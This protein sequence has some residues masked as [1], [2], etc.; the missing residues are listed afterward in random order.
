MK[1]M[2]KTGDSSDALLWN[3]LQQESQAAVPHV[4]QLK[5]STEEA[6]REAKMLREENEHAMSVLGPR[7]SH[8]LSDTASQMITPLNVGGIISGVESCGVGLKTSDSSPFCVTAVKHVLDIM[9]T[10]QVP[11]HTLKRAASKMLH[12]VVCCV[13]SVAHAE[14]YL[15]SY[16]QG[17]PN[18]LNDNIAVGDRIVSIDGFDAEGTPC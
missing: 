11:L 12:R 15:L 3:A 7:R 13:H 2:H 9:R 10:A 17:Q 5:V 4:Q 8:A 14:P 16:T 6:E 18:Y 1:T